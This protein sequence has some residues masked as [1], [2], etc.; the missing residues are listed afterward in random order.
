MKEMDFSILSEELEDSELE[1]AV[2]EVS[3]NALSDNM[4]RK[5]ITLEGYIQENPIMILVDTGST[6]SFLDSK[7]VKKCGLKTSK[8]ETIHVKLADGR[9]VTSD[10][11]IP[12]VKWKVQE[13]QF[14]GYM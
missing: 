8:G 5:T 13:Y 2:A 10:S 1:G 3:L 6:M 11:F 4:M 7:M 14:C 12:K 9:S